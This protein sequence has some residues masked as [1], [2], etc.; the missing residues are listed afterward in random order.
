MDEVNRLSVARQA[1]PGNLYYTAHLQVYLPVEGIQALD[2]GVIISRAYYQVSEDGSETAVTTAN[3]GDILLARLTIVVPK[4]LHYLVIDDPLPAGLELVDEAL[5]TSPDTT[6]P[7]RDNW[8]SRW[9]RGWRWWYFNHIELRDEKVVLSADYLPAGTYVFTYIVRA[10][11]PGA[12]NVIPPIAQEF[13]FPE[14]YGRG[15]GSKFTVLP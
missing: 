8:S 5:N 13:Y 9:R 3:Q 4:A 6:A 15:A 1:G 10:S 2:R 11:T 7:L 14:V 12:Y